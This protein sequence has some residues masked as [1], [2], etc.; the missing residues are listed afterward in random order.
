MM[1]IELWNL[2][3]ITTWFAIK[4]TLFQLF[5]CISLHCEMQLYNCTQSAR[6]LF[7]CSVW[8]QVWLLWWM[9]TEIWK[10][11]CV[12][13]LHGLVWL[14]T[15]HSSYRKSGLFFVYV[16]AHWCV[17][18]ILFLV[19]W[20]WKIPFCRSFAYMVVSLHH[21]IHWIISVPLIAYKR[22]ATEFPQYVW[23]SC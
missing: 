2:L 11:K 7:T 16:V 15:S 1:L 19:W 9:L 3:P 17:N 5:S 8:L 22:L 12:E 14:F 4:Y 20:K 6:V 18:S 13:V 23:T 10:C 21:W